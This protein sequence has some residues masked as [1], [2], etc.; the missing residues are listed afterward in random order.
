MSD[1]DEIICVCI[2]I[3]C[4]PFPAYINHGIL[5]LLLQPVHLFY[6]QIWWFGATSKALLLSSIGDKEIT[7]DNISK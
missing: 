1:Y 5:L 3:P 4:Q 2:I 6:V 7:C